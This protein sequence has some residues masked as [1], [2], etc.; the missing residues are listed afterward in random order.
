MRR[1]GRDDGLPLAD[2]G[3]LM[4][5]NW[6]RYGFTPEAVRAWVEERPAE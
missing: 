2:F 6:N 4:R 3:L 5:D 1:H